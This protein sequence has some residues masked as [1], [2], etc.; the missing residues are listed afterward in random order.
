MAKET[1]SRLRL[2]SFVRGRNEDRVPCASVLI[3][4]FKTKAV[5]KIAANSVFSCEY[6]YRL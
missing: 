6:S 5:L 3:T 2:V 1:I 4:G